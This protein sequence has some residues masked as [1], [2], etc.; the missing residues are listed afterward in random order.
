MDASE[1]EAGP[2]VIEILPTEPLDDAPPGVT[3]DLPTFAAGLVQERVTN[4]PRDPEH[5]VCVVGPCRYYME[6]FEPAD[7]MELPRPLKDTI[8]FCHAVTPTLD[9]SDVPAIY[10]CT[11]W[12]PL[13][14]EEALMR[15][16]RRQEHPEKKNWRYTTWPP[17][18]EK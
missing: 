12:T 2:D 7:T 18:K 8:R 3:S 9:I 14:S 5:L 15:K 13:H 17:N 16:L 4:Y 10:D 6:T 11:H 1:P